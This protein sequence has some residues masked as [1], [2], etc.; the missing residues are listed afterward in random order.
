MK[1]L[2]VVAFVALLIGSCA[3]IIGCESGGSDDSDS[4]G[5]TAATNTP[6]GPGAPTDDN[7]QLSEFRKT[8]APGET[9]SSGTVVSPGAG[10]IETFV[11]IAEDH[12]EV[13]T[14]FD[15][16]T[17]A[18]QTLRT[19]TAAGQQWRTVAQNN[20]AVTFTIRVYMTYTP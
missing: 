12:L 13:Q 11:V 19:A 20:L 15:E 16:K 10:F 4:D 6:T 5:G 14:W 17:G 8:L 3:L 1:H 18:M 9:W 2:W 7:T